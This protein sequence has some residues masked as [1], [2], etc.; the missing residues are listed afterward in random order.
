[1]GL[2]AG[3]ALQ[4]DEAINRQNAKLVEA[5]SHDQVIKSLRERIEKQTARLEGWAV[6][7]RSSWGEAKTLHLRHG[8]IGF[9]WSARSVRL[10]KD[11]TEAEVLL[12]LKRLGKWWKKEFIRVKEELHRARILDLSRPEAVERS[13]LTPAALKQ[14]G[15]EIARE[16][17]FFAEPK[18]EDVT[19]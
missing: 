11:W 10:L 17:K 3:L 6:S 7:T 9:K 16:E 13:G 5:R 15:L 12:K 4:L 14:I 8:D 1:M 2:I 19:P 18:F